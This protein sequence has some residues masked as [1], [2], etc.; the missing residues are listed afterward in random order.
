VAQVNGKVRA[1]INVA[2]DADKNI[3]EETAL[4]DDN[5]LKHIG[6]KPVKKVIVVPNKLINIVV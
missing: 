6:D 3:V 1:K 5:I 4:A 2:A